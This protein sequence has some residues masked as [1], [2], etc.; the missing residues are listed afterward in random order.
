MGYRPTIQRA[1][2]LYQLPLPLMQREVSLGMRVQKTE[3]PLVA[4]M[5]PRSSVRKE[6][7]F[8][9]SGLIV[10]GN[11][12][13]DDRTLGMVTSLDVEQDLLTEWL[14]GTPEPFTFYTHVD[15]AEVGGVEFGF[16][17]DRF[18]KNC[19]CEDLRFSDTNKSTL[20]RTY[21]F[22]LFVPDGQLYY[23]E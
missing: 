16:A 11:P 4:G 14:I 9:C 8:N 2:G 20:V 5:L 10:I 19:L 21:S 12:Q 3:V 15:G 1:A 17:K 6:A 22:T 23:T 7:Y 13:D 18:Y